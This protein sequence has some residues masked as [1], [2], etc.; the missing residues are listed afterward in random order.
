MARTSEEKEQTELE[1]QLG[2]AATQDFLGS[3]V[4]KSDFTSWSPWSKLPTQA[5]CC[6]PT[7]L[8]ME[9]TCL[10]GRCGIAPR[11]RAQ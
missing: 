3:G 9:W 1:K 8:K 5:L 4:T 6:L 11:V 7:E 10:P 2:A